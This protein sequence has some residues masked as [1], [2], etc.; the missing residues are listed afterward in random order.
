MRQRKS[1]SFDCAYVPGLTVPSARVREVMATRSLRNRV[2]SRLS[3]PAITAEAEQADDTDADR[4]GHV[5]PEDWVEPPV[6]RLPPSFQD[7]RGLERVGVLELQQP[8]GEPPSQ[9]LLQRLKLNFRPSNRA[10]PMQN[11]EGVTP[12]VESERLEFGSPRQAERL[13]EPPPPAPPPQDGPIVFSSPPRGRPAKR[14]AD[15]MRQ[16][17]YIMDFAPFQPLVSTSPGAAA[18]SKP[19]S[20]QEQLRQDRV[21]AY[22]DKAIEEAERHGDLGLLPGLQK[23]KDKAFRQRSLWVVLDAIAH[24]SP[25]EEQLSV[26]KRYI[27]K[28]VKRHRRHS[29]FSGSSAQPSFQSQSPGQPVVA[30]DD[31]HTTLSPAAPTLIPAPTF[32]PTFRTRPSPSRHPHT[33]PAHPPVHLS[34]SSRRS[35]M[36]SGNDQSPGQPTFSNT[37]RRKRS[38]SN[39]STSSLSSARSIPEEFA[40][41]QPETEGEEGNADERP[42]SKNLKGGQRQGSDRAKLRSSGISHPNSKHP[43][44]AFP[45][46]AKLAAKKLKKPKEDLDYD[47][48]DVERRR[49]RYEDDILQDY[50]YRH[51]DTVNL[52]EPLAYLDEDYPATTTAERVLPPPIVHAHPVS[53]KTTKLDSSF[54]SRSAP[55]KSLP[56]GT[57]RKRNYDEME[58][59]DDDLSWMFSLTPEPIVVPPPPVGVRLASR[60]NT[61][62]M[63]K[64]PALNKARKS[65]R[66]MIS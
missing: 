13:S 38:G 23:V 43:F 50:N 2:P 35:K 19:I 36:D 65:A 31:S 17:A 54:E 7:H 51:H 1:C 61:P 11:E 46:V 4:N 28:G 24:N 58:D 39:S 49:R 22:I 18:A 32:T 5:G 48:A 44:H 41:E 42:R 59:D 6:R 64:H 25:D 57:G 60:A 9:K 14:D 10:S 55:D 45:D 8:L 33:H 3:S 34:P 15:E 27:K 30:A 66:V 21:S 62:R 37:H 26:F 29:A 63:A 53:A 52:R 12:S 20:I 56:N 16:P 40:P 47:P